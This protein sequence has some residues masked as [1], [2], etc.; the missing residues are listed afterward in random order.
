M[1]EPMIQLIVSN[2]VATVTLNRPD[3]HNALN[4]DMAKRLLDT[5]LRLDS[6][7][8]VRVVV[9][10][11]NGDS[12]CAGADLKWMAATPTD[13]QQ[14]DSSV[15]Q[16]LATLLYTLYHLNKPTIVLVNGDVYGGGI[17]LVVCCDIALASRK[18]QFCFSEVRLGLIPAVISPYVVN[19]IGKRAARRYLL[20]AEKFPAQQAFDI[21][22]VHEVLADN[23]LQNYTNQLCQKLIQA[24]PGALSRTKQLVDDVAHCQLDNTIKARTA[25]W[26][27]EVRDTAEAREGI[28]AFLEKRQAKWVST[29]RE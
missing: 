11:A 16:Q 26:L 29:N 17:G 15:E 10:T 20:T 5:F 22:L 28:S 24:G 4:A 3:V 14:N 19:A 21:G 25:T 6:N 13:Q 8:S 23:Q 12:F 2:G 1:A 18:A 27:T 9:L 7:Q